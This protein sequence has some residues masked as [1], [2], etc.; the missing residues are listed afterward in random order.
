MTKY[1]VLMAESIAKTIEVE[2]N[3]ADEARDMVDDG[4]WCDNDIIKEDVVDRFAIE[5][6]E[7]KDGKETD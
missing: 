2:A 4:D 1:H 3:S 5:A 6:E 7:V